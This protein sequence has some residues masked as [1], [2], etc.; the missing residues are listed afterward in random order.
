M[1][2]QVAFGGRIDWPNV[3][4]FH[5]LVMLFWLLRDIYQEQLG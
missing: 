1:L 3:F 5:F 4:V 2:T